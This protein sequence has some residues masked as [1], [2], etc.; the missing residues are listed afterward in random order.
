MQALIADSKYTEAISV[1]TKALL[2]NG[3]GI[4]KNASFATEFKPVRKHLESGVAFDRLSTMVEPKAVATME[5]MNMLSFCALVY[6]PELVPILA[7]RMVKLT[8]ESGLAPSSPFAISLLG[9][10]LIL[11]GVDFELGA[12]CTDNSLSLVDALVDKSSR[13]RAMTIHWG[14]CSGFF[15]PWSAGQD[16][17]KTSYRFCM[18]AGD[19][20]V[21]VGCLCR[22]GCHRRLI[23]DIC[24]IAVWDDLPPDLNCEHVFRGCGGASIDIECDGIC[25]QLV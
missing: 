6:Q 18:R 16:A 5:V 10:I 15:K 19:S 9:A 8:Y 4:K 2:K 14:V 7:C 1:G 3:D 24:C 17:L 21:S 25:V 22:K 20:E 13:G 12:R 23:V 11:H